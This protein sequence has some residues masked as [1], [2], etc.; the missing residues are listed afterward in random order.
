MTDK[1]PTSYLS[2]SH[3]VYIDSPMFADCDKLSFLSKNLY[4]S[5]V[6]YIRQY[7]FEH[8]SLKADKLWVF[9]SANLYHV[10]KDTQDFK[11]ELNPDMNG[12]KCN[13]KILKCTQRQV[14]RCFTGY[15]GAMKSYSKNKSKFTGQPKLPSYK[16]KNGRNEV[17]V[18]KEAISFVKEKGYACI[19]N[20][21]IKVKL[22]NATKET[23][24]E[25]KIIPRNGYYEIFVCYGVRT[26][27]PLTNEMIKI[28]GVDFGINN[29][30]T[31]SS[32]DIGFKPFL[33]NGRHIKSINQF[34]NKQKAKMQ[35]QLPVGIHWSKALSRLTN[36][37]NDK[38]HTEMHNA[39]TY[40]VKELV[41]RGI[42]TLIVGWNNGIKQNSNMGK[43]TNQSF[44]SIPFY[45]LRNMLK[46]KCELAGIKYIETEESYTSK[47]SFLDLEEMKKQSNY[48]GN[49]TKRGLFVS[50]NG[51]KINADLNGS[52]NIIRKVANN[53]VFK[54]TN[55]SELVEGYAVSPV[56]VSIATR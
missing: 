47:C 52:L 44:T 32:N 12:Y 5:A 15:I 1:A 11:T 8:D 31:V 26:I 41:D 35:S 33:I 17:T 37:R 49:R 7:N 55:I 34:Y 22:I 25:I 18:P 46:Y 54:Y 6:Y 20:S 23:L 13:T 3:R 38:L 50:S 9:N 42:D 14:E 43:K 45:K 56:K 53:E 28:A 51:H 36:K 10:Q 2:E 21:N 48:I 4:N 29:L 30:M 40:L 39:S 16:P 27:E 19:A 24:K